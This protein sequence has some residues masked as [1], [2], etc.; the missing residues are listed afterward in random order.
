[1]GKIVPKLKQARFNY[2]A[3]LG[4]EV[5]I[6]EVAKAIGIT[7]PHLSNLENG[8]ALPGWDILRA[9]CSLY[10]VPL[11]DLVEYSEEDLAALIAA[12]A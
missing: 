4:R 8:K 10:G 12:L 2:Q 11:S 1:M 7:R 6:Q 5:T 9:L 3:R